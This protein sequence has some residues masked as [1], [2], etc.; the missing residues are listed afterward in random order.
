MGCGADNAEDCD[1]AME[2]QAEDT[3]GL[4]IQNSSNGTLNGATDYPAGNGL[5]TDEQ[6]SSAAVD[7]AS[8]AGLTSIQ[9]KTY[10]KSDLAADAAISKVTVP[11]APVV[12]ITLSSTTVSITEG[13]RRG[14][15]EW[16]IQEGTTDDEVTGGTNFHHVAIDSE[17]NMIVMGSTYGDYVGTNKGYSDIVYAKFDPTGKKLWS[18]QLGTTYYELASDG[19]IDVDSND[20]IYMFFTRSPAAGQAGGKLH[21][22]KKVDKDG[23]N[24]WDQYIESSS[25]DINASSSVM[26]VEGNYL[27]LTRKIPDGTD[28]LQILKYDLDGNQVAT[29]EIIP[30]FTSDNRFTSSIAVDSSG[31]YV[32]AYSYLDKASDL[33]KLPLDLSSQ[34]LIQTAS[35]MMFEEIDLLSNG[36][37]VVLAKDTASDPYGSPIMKIFNSSGTQLSSG[38]KNQGDDNRT[39]YA[40]R[41]NYSVVDSS[42]N[43]I[44]IQQ[45][46]S[47]NKEYYLV[48]YDS[49]GNFINEKRF[50]KG[51]ATPTSID[52]RKPSGE[53]DDI[54]AA[55]ASVFPNGIYGDDTLNYRY[56]AGLGRF[57]NSA[58]PV[59]STPGYADVMFSVDSKPAA[60]VYICP[61][62]SSSEVV[63]IPNGD[64]SFSYV[65]GY[66]QKSAWNCAYIFHDPG[67]IYSS[68][69][70]KFYAVQDNVADGDKDVSVGFT[71]HSD[72][73]AWDGMTLPNVTVTVIDA[74]YAPNAPVHLK[75][76][77][78]GTSNILSW[79][80]PPTGLGETIQS[81]TL[82][83]NTDNGTSWTT[84]TGITGTTYTH[85]G[86]NTSNNYY[87]EVFANGQGGAGLFQIG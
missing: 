80:K 76:T 20:N 12:G 65:S 85:S 77:P 72:D 73:T 23:S 75:V 55:A 16:F 86:V 2:I 15:A 39:M 47:K 18:K 70:I 14:D 21:R 17:M 4:M 71:V 19:G 53:T 84:V 64:R 78:S 26:I 49:S 43:I 7:N 9:Q 35:D 33:I 32:A 62:Y 37:I 6:V 66:N 59:T 25:T 22:I 34:T 57:N 30:S 28:K 10:F 29:K 31:V 40:S 45:D 79:Y 27:Y 58:A 54:I 41:R 68:A 81:Y 5:Y 3:A 60:R 51:N 44:F 11:A 48:K 82:K 42:D 87:Y 67:S 69:P 1:W 74:N 61:N 56:T 46:M 24:V 36:N 83:W 13:G 50:P 52:L 38:R 8:Y 63:V